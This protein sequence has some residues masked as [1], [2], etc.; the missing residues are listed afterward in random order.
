MAG[1]P[2][3][4]PA[5]SGRAERRTRGRH[6]GRQDRRVTPVGLGKM[7]VGGSGGSVFADGG[8]ARGERK[9][10]PCDLHRAA[11]PYVGGMLCCSY[12]LVSMRW[13]DF[14]ANAAM[15]MLRVAQTS[16]LAFGCAAS[17]LMSL[18]GELPVPDWFPRKAGGVVNYTATASE[19]FSDATVRAKVVAI[20]HTEKSYRATINITARSKDRELK[21]ISEDV[22]FIYDGA[23]LTCTIAENPVALAP[24]EAS[25]AEN[26][27]MQINAQVGGFAWVDGATVTVLPKVEEM[28]IGGHEWKNVAAAKFVQKGTGSTVQATAHFASPQGL[29]R[30]K[31]A[32]QNNDGSFRVSALFE[33]VPEAVSKP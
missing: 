23:R 9:G 6:C 22:E 19:Q 18:G 21:P 1:I 10:G 7:F 12:P 8:E 15:R 20:T 30:L 3:Q 27:E 33:I 4:R 13:N 16:F 28:V 29:L 11:K 24:F 2:A 25:P 26:S 14:G 17:S 32:A 5:R 31:T